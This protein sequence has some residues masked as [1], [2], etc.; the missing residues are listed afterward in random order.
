MK[1][2]RNTGHNRLGKQGEREI[3]RLLVDAGYKVKD[4]YDGC[5]RTVVNPS[6][7]EMLH[8]EIKTARKSLKGYQFCVRKDG[9]TSVD[10]SDLVILLCVH[11]SGRVR[12]FCFK[13]CEIKGQ[14][15]TITSAKHWTDHE[16]DV[17]STIEG[18]LLPVKLS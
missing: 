13:P 5:D 14:L 3:E 8:I 9:H 17:V 18:L 1:L 12:S 10:F 2:F 16:C 4:G 7:G 6:T 11:D 15:L